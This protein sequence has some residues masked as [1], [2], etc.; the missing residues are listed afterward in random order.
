MWCRAVTKGDTPTP[1]QHGS[2]PPGP[3]APLLR[4]RPPFLSGPIIPLLPPRACTVTLSR[5]VLTPDGASQGMEAPYPP[6]TRV[7]RGRGDQSSCHRLEEGRAGVSGPLQWIEL[8]RGLLLWSSPPCFIRP[9]GS[10]TSSSHFIRT[11]KGLQEGLALKM[12]LVPHHRK[13]KV[14]SIL[15]HLCE[16]RECGPQGRPRVGRGGAVHTDA[17]A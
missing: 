1:D 10:V 9:P 6:S 8:P 13:S 15:M 12:G 5:S 16:E 7:Y 4:I 17:P 3:R 14:K 11:L 2:V